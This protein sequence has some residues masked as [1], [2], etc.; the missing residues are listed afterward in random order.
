MD[1]SYIFTKNHGYARMKDLK[2]AGVHTRKVAA[3]LQEGSITRIKPGLYKLADF[4]EDEHSNFTDICAANSKAV[5]CLISAAEY[6]QLTTMNPATVSIA[7][8]E[9][10]VQPRLHEL[11][12]SYYYFRGLH[13]SIEIETIS[14]KSGVFRIYSIEKTIAD[15]FRYYNK[16]GSDIVLEVIKNYLKRKDKN[17]RKLTSVGKTCGAKRLPG[18]LEALLG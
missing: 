3:A 6:Y 5:I 7:L 4:Y 16:I 13:Y 8:P 2:L 11:P 9:N 18:V 1:F 14:V 10:S 15:L 17:I 12:L